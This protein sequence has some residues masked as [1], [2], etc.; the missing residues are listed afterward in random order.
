MPRAHFEKINNVLFSL[1]GGCREVKHEQIESCQCIAA[2]A[3]EPVIQQQPGMKMH[4]QLGKLLSVWLT[5][6]KTQS[7][8]HKNANRYR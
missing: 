7:S 8:L 4:K 1:F 5:C 3:A 6:S 2:A